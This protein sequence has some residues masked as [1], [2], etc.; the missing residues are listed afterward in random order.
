MPSITPTPSKSRLPARSVALP[1]VISLAAALLLTLSGAAAG[2]PLHAETPD[3]QP[4][5]EPPTAHSNTT[6]PCPM[7]LPDG[8]VDGK[9]VVCGQIEVPLDWNVRDGKTITITY[10][11]A[12]AHSKAA[13]AD[14]IVYFEGGPGGTALEDIEGLSKYFD[15]LRST[16]D[17]IYYDQRGTRYS[18]NIDC[19]MEVQYPDMA[20]PID[21]TSAATDTTGT[22]LDANGEFDF[23]ALMA[24]MPPQPTINDDPTELLAKA[25]EEGP[26]AWTTNCATY[27]AEHKVDLSAF[28]T[29]ASAQ[30]AVALLGALGYDEYNLYGISYGTTVVL[31]MLRY[32]DE[33]PELAL[34]PL[35]SVVVDGVMPDYID[36]LEQSLLT[37]RILLGIFQGCE[38]DARCRAAYPNLIQRTADLLSRL[39]Q[40]PIVADDG[41]NIG[42]SQVMDTI[43]Q[44]ITAEDPGLIVYVP[45]LVSELEK[46]DLTVYTR[47]AEG[48]LL[49]APP[50]PEA[51][52]ALFDPIANEV[53]DL[54][55]QQRALTDQIDLL[56]DESLRISKALDAGMTP[57]RLFAEEFV[58]SLEHL[59]ITAATLVAGIV[60][61]M[62]FAEPS[63]ETFESFV[64]MA[65]EK[66]RPL[67]Q[68]IVNLMSD[69]DFA[70]AQRLL[71]QP[72]Y[73]GRMLGINQITNAVVICNDFYPTMD[74]VATFD[75]L[76]AFPIP[77]FVTDP[78]KG[79]SYQINC[80]G[81]GLMPPPAP[82]LEPVTSSVRA[83]V[84]NGALDA[85][86]AVAWG[87]A[88]YRALGNA[89]MITFPMSVHG[90]SVRSD[91]AQ[92]ITY[93]FF[94]Y[95]DAKPNTA[96]VEA[97]KPTY[98]LPDDELPPP[99]PSAQE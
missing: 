25:R 14:P 40:E 73:A 1:L 68:S 62:T 41:S 37:P 26:A 57:A 35:R 8:D 97:L 43:Y 46:G 96:C 39:N 84:S 9:T 30:D 81:L 34:P 10:A 44:T 28:N 4:P 61:Q 89:E 2:R 29:A 77:Q 80:E 85:N 3:A 70:E 90:A 5:A 17:F 42:P 48:S 94:T 78:L 11:I 15:K 50:T 75:T 22:G 87:E 32:Y 83:L 55:E 31:E 27:L 65:E 66:D 19:P 6:V 18:A 98:V 99:P 16:R 12:K 86:T 13:F 71:R 69:E 24:S 23:D 7:T 54:V 74:L 92:D 63:R 47:L 82:R 72:V 59:D 79:L 88:A 56:A 38:A 67:L 53:K 45:R 60:E 76:R 95:P 51:P 93:A 64:S 20:K 58:S 91:C 49:T 36:Y 33:H 52:G 21:V